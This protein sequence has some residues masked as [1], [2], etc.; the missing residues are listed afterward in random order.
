M[1][2]DALKDFNF[3]EFFFRFR[4]YFLII[5]VGLILV[6][7]G[8]FIT[9]KEGIVSGT[10]IEVLEDITGGKEGKE[11]LVV[12]ISGEVEKPGVYNLPAGSRIEDV[13]IVAGGISKDADRV[14]VERNLNRAAKLSDG[15]KIYIPK[16]DE[17]SN[18]LSANNLGGY[19][20]ASSQNY[21]QGSDL[22]NINTAS[23]KELEELPDIGPTRAQN[24]IDNRF[25][26]SV[27]ELLSKKV[28]TKSVY[29]KVK[30]KVTTY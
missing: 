3:E 29:E 24:I 26:S 9:R 30:D 2:P 16:E 5:F 12:D 15:Q 13:L 8:V 10:K 28:L 23:Q 25:Y 27:E 11:S 21:S 20:T 22:V 19:Q 17:Q 1:L 7:V 18:S 14:W 6:G 4:F